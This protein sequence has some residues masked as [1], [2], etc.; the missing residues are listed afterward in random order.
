[1]IA[2]VPIRRRH[3]VYDPRL[4]ELVFHSGDA[5][6]ARQ[7]GAPRSTANDW[8]NGKFR[9]VATSKVFDKEKAILKPRT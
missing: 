2:P 6:I 1:M 5:A 8:V 3:R 9:D 7:F 4:R